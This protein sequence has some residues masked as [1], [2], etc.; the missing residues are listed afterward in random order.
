MESLDQSWVREKFKGY[1]VAFGLQ[2]HNASALK[3]EKIESY[4]HY[5]ILDDGYGAPNVIE[6]GD[7]SLIVARNYYG[8]PTGNRPYSNQ[9]KVFKYPFLLGSSGILMFRVGDTQYHFFVCWSGPRNFYTHS[10]TLVVGLTAGLPVQVQ[11]YGY[12]ELFN[13]LY[14]GMEILTIKD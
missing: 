10:N 2:I 6:S 7:G 12:T 8:Y 1:S 4:L 5:G 14:Y 13:K 9:I 3:L 11:E